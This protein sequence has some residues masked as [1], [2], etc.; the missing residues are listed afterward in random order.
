MPVSKNTLLVAKVAKRAKDRIETIHRLYKDLYAMAEVNTQ[1]V[2]WMVLK[3]FQELWQARGANFNHLTDV[4]ENALPFN[5]WRV[6]GD[7]HKAD[8]SFTGKEIIEAQTLAMLS[9]IRLTEIKYLE[10]YED[11]EVK[12]SILAEE[13]EAA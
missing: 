5:V 12:P 10:G 2:H 3:A 8:K 13:T 1:G 4:L 7:I 6:N 9:Y 11:V